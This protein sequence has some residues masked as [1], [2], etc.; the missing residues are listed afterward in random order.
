[1][2]KG[3]NNDDKI[4]SLK[5]IFPTFLAIN[6]TYIVCVEPIDNLQYCFYANFN[7]SFVSLHSVRF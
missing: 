4:F 7:I 5:F 6:V 3:A 2:K 1:M